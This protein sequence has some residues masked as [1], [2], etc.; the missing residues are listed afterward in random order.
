VIAVAAPFPFRL[1]A[2]LDERFP[3]ARYAVLI[4]SYYSSNQ[5]LAQALTRPAE[6]VHYDGSSVRGAIAL[7]CVFLLLRVCDEHKDYQEDCRHFPERVLQ[8][9]LVTLHHLKRLGGGAIAVALALAVYQGP[10]ALAA[11]GLVFAFGGLMGQEFFLR[12]WLRRHLL[13]YAGLHLL[14]MP[15]LA[16][17]VYSFSTDRPP[18][19]APGWF[20]VYALVGFF[21]AFNWEV[22]R[23]IRAPGEEIAGVDSYTRRFGTYGAAY[24][25]LGIRVVDT[26]L[27][28]LVGRHLG[29][30]PG[31][32]AVLALLFAVGMVGFLHYRLR[33][34]PATARR[35][36]FYA[37]LY[38]AAFDL[39]LTVELVRLGP[40]GGGPT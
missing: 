17:L 37:G 36:E 8:R 32:Y 3:L 39:A 23:K 5:F 35:M 25:V 28:C 31:F 40:L 16:L 10:A 30:S 24:V 26:L 14:I 22:S 21:V 12:P 33:T 13:L 6:G 18:W 19:R 7:F 29:L 15:L 20:W 2:Y 27:V 11:L 4:A 1:K 34:S 38:V 9:G